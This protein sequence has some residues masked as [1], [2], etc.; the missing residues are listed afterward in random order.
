M[1]PHRSE[2]VIGQA[3]GRTP[4]NGQERMYPLNATRFLNLTG[5]T[6]DDLSQWIDA[7]GVW[8]HQFEF[9]NGVVTPGNDPSAE[10]L[11][12][13]ALPD[14]LDGMSVI[15]VGAM[16]GYFSFQAEARG[17]ARVVATDHYMWN[18]SPSVLENLRL[19][20]RVLGSG[21]EEQTVSVEDLSPDT[22]GSFDVALFLGVLYHAPNMVQ[23]LER[24]RSVTKVF[25]VVETLVDMLHV[26]EP[27]AAYYPRLS[28]NQDPTNWWGPN[29][30]CVRDMLERVGFSR[31]EFKGLWHLN[32]L[33]ALSG[34]SVEGR[35]KSGRAVWHAHV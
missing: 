16:E 21:V 33:E 27:C 3:H 20:K 30:A 6:A 25:A 15:D 22:V 14:R 28:L 24:L 4:R 10:K 11:H 18:W 34:R 31:V 32:T 19:V 5:A 8:F 2:A 1:D 13:L 9:D 7:R 12:A 26:D 29:L 23:Y 17:A 35:I